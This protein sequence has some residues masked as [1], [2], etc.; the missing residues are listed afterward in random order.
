M[1]QKSYDRDKGNLF[2]VPTPIGNLKDITYRAVEVLESVDAIYA[3][4]TRVTIQLL[5]SLNIKNKVYPCHKFN[6]VKVSEEII[7]RLSN[8]NNVAIV[9]DRGTPLISDPGSIVV[10]NVVKANFN[11]IALP[12][13]SAVLPALNMSTISSEK[14]LFYGFLSSKESQSI[15]ELS[16]LKNIKFTI[17]LYEAPHRLYKTLQNMLQTLGNR[18]I[19]ISREISKLHEEVFRG[20]VKEALEI[21]ENVKGEIVIVIEKEEEKIDYNSLILSVEE[22]VS[23]GVSSK[24]AIKKISKDYNVSKN[25]LYKMYEEK[26]K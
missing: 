9:T 18:R 3:E 13:A 11:V 17:V 5:N 14:F 22:L 4:D 23:L 10:D 20:S 16:M 7:S 6:E 25:V 2:L 24:E 1:I 26:K 19:S 8:D 21:Y 12:G 15:K